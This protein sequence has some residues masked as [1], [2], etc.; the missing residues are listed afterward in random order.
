L[1]RGFP[2]RRQDI[3]CAKG[4]AILCVVFGHIVARADPIGVAWYE[5]LRRAVYAF[6]MPFFLYLSGIVT[7]FSGALLIP[8]AKFRALVAMRARRLLIPFFTMGVL[9]VCGKLLAR[10][11][12]FV[13]NQATSLWAGL[14]S[15]I[16]HTQDS[17]AISIWY[18]FVLFIM[19]I[20]SPVLIWADRGRPYILL[21]AGFF[22]YCV[23][24][25]AYIYLDH[26]GKYAVFFALGV[27]A[28]TRDESWTTFIDR[29]WRVL[30]SLLVCALA[31]IA[32]FGKFWPVKPELLLIG[33]LSMPALHGLVRHLPA[34]SATILLWLGRN[35][36]M[37]YL[38]NTIFIGFAKGLLLRM[39]DWDGPHFLFFA[40]F[41]MLSGTFGPVVLR[42]TL[43]RRVGILE[44][45]TK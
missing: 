7:V 44:R 43:F 32:G 36:F 22:L 1:H 31:L 6:H 11:L 8:P 35:S 29:Y 38:F 3:D 10:H 23:P 20:V 25:P 9:T 27:W 30:V 18:L 37:I 24:L 13:D 45:Y 33:A 5:P 12:V 41:L 19:S 42:Q 21:L 40:L 28:A 39:T 2:G 17:P 4:L 15:L 26:I 16:W 34:S 14:G